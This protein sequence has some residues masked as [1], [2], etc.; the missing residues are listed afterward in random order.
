MNVL[1][2]RTVGVTVLSLVLMLSLFASSAS[3]K[4]PFTDI[5]STDKEIHYLYDRGLIN[6]TTSTTFSPTLS[7]TREQAAAIIGRALKLNGTQRAT[8][9]PDVSRHSYASGYIQS[10][11]DAKILTGYPDGTFKPS[12]TMT[13][14]EMAY[15]LSRAFSLSQTSQVTFNDVPYNGQQTSLYMAINKI[16]TAGITNGTGNGNFSPNKQ[17]VRREFAIFIARALNEQFRVSFEDARANTLQST[18]DGL[19]VRSGPSTTHSIVGKVNKGDLVTMHRVENGWVYGTSGN[20]TGYFSLNFL[21][22]DPSDYRTRVFVLDPGHGGTDPGAVSN[23]TIEKVVNLDVALRVESKLKARGVTVLMT[24]RTDVFH[25][26]EYRAGFG[27][28][29]NADTFLSIHANAAAASVS[30]SETFYSASVVDDKRAAYSRQLATFVQDRLHVAMNHPNRGVKEADFRVLASNPL[31]SVL[32]ELGF[33]TNT[34]DAAKLR[35]PIFQDRAA[36]A[37]ADGIMDYYTWRDKQ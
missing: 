1:S 16:A 5:L 20:V 35:D 11:V 26:L 36:Q 34:T 28:Q 4:A 30:G 33:L 14:G 9:F 2:L 19:N 6:G 29:N 18:V 23:N 17:L 22:V 37:I 15:L 31:P 12:Q 25:S 10:A 13:R 3:A 32:V 8:S 27:L 24:R 7:V 21:T